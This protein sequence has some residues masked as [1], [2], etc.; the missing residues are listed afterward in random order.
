MCGAAVFEE[1]EAKW[2]QFNTPV[3][4]SRPAPPQ[5]EWLEEHEAQFLAA[6]SK[7]LRLE[8]K[9]AA[10]LVKHAK[11]GRAPEDPKV[12]VARYKGLQQLEARFAGF[13]ALETTLS[14]PSVLKLSSEKVFTAMLMFQD[15]FTAVSVGPTMPKL[16]RFIV[17]QPARL[18]RRLFSLDAAMRKT[19]GSPLPLSKLDRAS[20]FLTLPASQA[21]E[22]L[23]ACVTIFGHEGAATV[24]KK[25]PNLLNLHPQILNHNVLVLRSIITPNAADRPLVT[26][27]ITKLPPLALLP[28]LVP[29]ELISARFKAIRAANGNSAGARKALLEQPQ[30]LLQDVTEPAA[31]ADVPAQ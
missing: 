3:G 14:E 28:G 19:L 24:L 1:F 4:P 26:Q 16:G 10:A 27:L 21:E 13:S 25:F 9:D 22:R 20:N 7:D 31:A 8:A 12:F 29:A 17:D 23:Q 2:Q 11:A 5:R 15:N 6:L 30:L 18:A